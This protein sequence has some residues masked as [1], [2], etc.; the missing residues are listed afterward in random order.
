MDRSALTPHTVTSVEGVLAHVERCRRE[1]W[2]RSDEELELGV[3]SMAVPA[4]DRDGQVVGGLSMSVRAERMTMAE[5][6]DSLLPVL[7]RGR[8]A[9]RERLL[10]E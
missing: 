8:D 7:L 3:R 9:L 6:R 4:Y 1:G 10:R 2:A 5:F